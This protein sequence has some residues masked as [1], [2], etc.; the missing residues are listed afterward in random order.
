MAVWGNI[1]KIFQWMNVV[2]GWSILSLMCFNKNSNSKMFGFWKRFFFVIKRKCDH[3]MPILILRSQKSIITQPTGL[4]QCLM[5][6]ELVLWWLHFSFHTVWETIVFYG[7]IWRLGNSRTSSMWCLFCL[8][9]KMSWKLK[10]IKNILNDCP[11][12][13]NLHAMKGKSN[14]SFFSLVSLELPSSIL[15]VMWQ[16]SDAKKHR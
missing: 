13:S 9:V 10:N 1:S 2:S 4:V 12:I 11:T 6:T 14:K 15:V 8:D 7:R 5:S 16:Q 3:E